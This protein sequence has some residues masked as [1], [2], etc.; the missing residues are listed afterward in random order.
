MKL[1]LPLIIIAVGLGLLAFT[2]Q[3]KEA[4]Q[5]ASSLSAESEESVQN[6]TQSGA[7]SQLAPNFTLQKLG[8]GTITL[9]EYKDKKPVIVNFWASWCPNCRRNLPEMNI[10]YHKYRDRIEVIAVNL[11]ES[12]QTIRDYLRSE[13]DR[14]LF[15]IALDPDATV[16]NQYGVRGTNVH[17]LIRKDGV[18]AG[19]LPGDIAEKYFQMLLK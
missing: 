13:S 17:F 15:P 16:T 8:G 9:A 4:G 3:P 2:S 1:I 5:T 7:G 19:I 10:L 6:T 11:Q 12:E 18:V 14:F